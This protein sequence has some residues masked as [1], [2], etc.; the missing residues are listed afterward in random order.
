MS[1][2]LTQVHLDAWT[3]QINRQIAE[4]NESFRVAAEANAPRLNRISAELQ[5]DFARAAA[6]ICEQMKLKP[7]GEFG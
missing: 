4:I 6:A 5:A 7:T 2:E 1:D 3:R